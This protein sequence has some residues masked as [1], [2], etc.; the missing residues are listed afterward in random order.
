MRSK[1]FYLFT[2]IS[3]LFIMIIFIPVSASASDGGD[4]DIYE[5]KPLTPEGN[6]CLVDDIDGEEAS[7]KQFITV[8]T[9]NGAYF[10]IIIDRAEDGE[11]TVHFLNQVDES[12]LLKL[13]D[14]EEIE[15]LI[16]ICKDK[17]IIGDINANCSAC[18]ISI[19]DCIG[20]VKETE[21]DKE[22]NSSIGLVIFTFVLILGGGAVF[23]YFKIYKPKQE[24]NFIDEE[25]E[26]EEYENDDGNEDIVL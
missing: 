3:I 17:C 13:I 23:Y 5:T 20:E 26:Y 11:N 10:Y 16:C 19:N 1:S 9:R 21:P 6:M 8:V 7:D 12:D 24:E 18:M 25:D 4:L 2:F 22:N 15:P 14:E